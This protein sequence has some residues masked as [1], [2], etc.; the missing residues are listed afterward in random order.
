MNVQAI[1]DELILDIPHRRGS[2]F[3]RGILAGGVATAYFYA[4]IGRNASN[5]DITFMARTS[6]LS[7]TQAS[8]I[9]A[10][11]ATLHVVRVARDDHY[12]DFFIRPGPDGNTR[13]G[14]S[15]I[16]SF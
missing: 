8:L 6:S 16:V 9:Y 12:T 1:A 4:T 14:V 7:K 5:S 3:E 13:V 15:K 10:G 11:I 2:P